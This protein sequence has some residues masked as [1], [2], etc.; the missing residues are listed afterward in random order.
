MRP[1]AL[2]T[3]DRRAERLRSI[4]ASSTREAETAAAL[5][6]R[7]PGLERRGAAERTLR[8]AVRWDLPGVSLDLVHLERE[9]ASLE[10][11]LGIE[12]VAPSSGIQPR[13]MGI[14]RRLLALQRRSAYTRAFLDCS[15]IQEEDIEPVLQEA[16]RAERADAEAEALLQG[17][18]QCIAAAEAELLAITAS[19]APDHEAVLQG[20]VNVGIERGPPWAV[21][22]TVVSAGVRQLEQGKLDGRAGRLWP[23]MVLGMQTF[24]RRL[25]T[26]WNP[27]ND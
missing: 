8:D 16:Q 27:R 26:E 19:R 22:P 14:A 3:L 7:A 24:G 12:H 23:R 15:L 5:L 11:A 17:V 4:M 18:E 6:A 2:L 21:G 9:A 13:C 20:A 25:R 10:R 1:E